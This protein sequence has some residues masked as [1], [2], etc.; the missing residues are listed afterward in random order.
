MKILPGSGF[1]I[2]QRE[3]ELRKIKHQRDV[4]DKPFRNICCIPFLYPHNGK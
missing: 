4:T 3:K 2:K 1:R